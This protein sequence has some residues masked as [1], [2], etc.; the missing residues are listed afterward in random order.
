MQGSEFI[1]QSG[2]AALD[3]YGAVEIADSFIDGPILV[4]SGASLTVTA[5]GTLDGS[6]SLAAGATLTIEPTIAGSVNLDATISGAGSLTIG[7]P[8]TGNGE[9]TLVSEAS[10]FSGGTVIEGGATV[11]VE[12]DAS[13]GTGAVT[14]AGAG[15]TLILDDDILLNT[16][17]SAESGALDIRAYMAT[18]STATLDAAIGTT[19][20]VE[21]YDYSVDDSAAA[22]GLTLGGGGTIELD[23][24]SVA[25]TAGVALTV[26][27]DTTASLSND[28]NDKLQGEVVVDAGA[29]AEF[30]STTTI[31]AVGATALEIEG[32]SAILDAWTVTGAT[33]VAD[34]VLAVEEGTVSSAILLDATSTLWVQPADDPITLAAPISGDGAVKIGAAADGALLVTSAD[35]YAG[36]TTIEGGDVVEV[37]AGAS[38]GS[39]VVTLDGPGDILRFD[40]DV[41]PTETIDFASDNGLI[42]LTGIGAAAAQSVALNASGQL[43]FEVGTT[44]ETLEI[45]GVPA[46]T[47]FDVAADGGGT[48]VFLAA[49]T[50]DVSS[51]AA[52]AQALRAADALPATPDGASDTIAL[53]RGA[54]EVILT[55]SVNLD[56]TAAASIVDASGTGSLSDIVLASGVSLGLDAADSFAGGIEIGAGATLTLANTEAAGTGVVNFAGPDGTLVTVPGIANLISGFS[57]GDTLDATSV[58]ATAA[59]DRLQGPSLAVD[60]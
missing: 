18:G 37:A 52:L 53:D 17:V 16:D 34:G 8:A 9:L 50:T 44:P 22:S 59:K 38:L 54:G 39:G 60:Q 41:P 19:L 46:G 13:L 10:S 45:A 30:S 27:A 24:L 40:G 56:S 23:Q 51:G 20:T 21:G 42:E 14:L 3:D 4:E 12:A 33:D 49:Q 48:D 6:V 43:V 26:A 7:G 55:S 31:D 2:G 35:S 15:A 32:G 47:L 58:V 57:A 11:D 28:A 5:G 1:A 29:V 25:T 36:G